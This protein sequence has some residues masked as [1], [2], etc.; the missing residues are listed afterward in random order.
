MW[1]LEI[2]AVYVRYKFQPSSIHHPKSAVSCV[3]FY[4]LVPI[5]IMMSYLILYIMY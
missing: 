4:A 1:Y 3:R 5:F 2:F